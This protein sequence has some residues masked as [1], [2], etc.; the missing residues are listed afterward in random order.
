MTK[1]GI[2]EA[3][4]FSYA[5]THDKS[6]VWQREDSSSFSQ[7]KGY[8]SGICTVYELDFEVI[9]SADGEEVIRIIFSH[10]RSGRKFFKVD[11]TQRI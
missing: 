5:T 2:L 7:A 8:I 11:T 9:K 10:Q 3:A 6:K 4:A 1:K